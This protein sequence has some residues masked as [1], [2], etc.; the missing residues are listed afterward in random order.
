MKTN[1]IVLTILLSTTQLKGQI[2]TS[3]VKVEQ[4]N[5][6]TT[7]L[8]TLGVGTSSPETPF[9]V[10]ANTDDDI[11][12]YFE[13]SASSSNNAA[14]A[15]KGAKNGSTSTVSFINF[16]IFDSDEANPNFTM[17]RIGA[18]KENGDGENGQ[19]RFYTFNGFLN[20]RMRIKANGFIGIGTSSPTNPLHVKAEPNDDILGYFEQSAHSS[21][22]AAIAIKGAKNGSTGT[23]SYINFD[24]FDWDEANPTFTMGR[25]GAGKENGVG[26]NGQLR[27]YTYDGTLNERM[28][29]KANGNVGIGLTNPNYNL[30]VNGS[31]KGTTLHTST[32]S[33]S[34]FVFD[35][36]Y[37]LRTLEEVEN[38]ISENKQLP[39]IPSETEVTENGINLG[40]M[41]AKLLQKIEELTLY[42]IEEHKSN[43][44]L[45]EKVERLEKELNTLKNE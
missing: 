23:V 20:E 2:T 14:I 28:R 3:E 16:D 26:E 12:G 40:E 9:H 43:K 35:T 38:Y 22:N 17:G 29:I 31:I 18:G 27:F 44:E 37:E 10:K 6:V 30:E 24:I 34:D 39:E 13:Q 41:D 45:A 8:G 7:I 32:Q 1:L 42:L 4:T 15:I 5:D 11:L 19:L 25:I 21:K 36:D 33:W